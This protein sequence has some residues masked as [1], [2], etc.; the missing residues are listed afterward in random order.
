MPHQM[1]FCAD[2]T[3]DAVAMIGGFGS[4]K[5]K[6]FCYKTV[7]LAGLNAGYEGAIM[8]PTNYLTKHHLVPNLKAVLEELKIPYEYESSQIFHLHFREGTT[9]IYC[10]SGE[11]YERLVGYNLA[12]VGSDETDTSDHLIA[13]AMWEKAIARIRVG[14]CRQIYSTSTPEGYRFLHEYF[15]EQPNKAGTLQTIIGEAPGIS[16]YVREYRGSVGGISRRSIHC[17]SYEN[18]IINDGKYLESMRANYTDQQWAVWALGQFGNLLSSK[19]YYAFDRKE[20]H[21]DLTLKDIPRTVSLAVGMD[22][23]IDHMAAVIHVLTKDGPRAIAELVNIK[24]TP[25]MIQ[26]LKTDPELRGRNLIIYPDSSGKNR[27]SVGVNTNISLLEQAGFKC[28]YN[29]TNPAVGDRVNSMNAMFKNADGTRRYLV[30][31]KTCPVYTSSLEKQARLPNGEP[32]KS[33][34]IDHPLDAAGYAIY[35]HY[36]L[37]GRPKVTQHE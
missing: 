25:T 19:V 4:G 27:T 12:F 30:N 16:N 29:P 14:K 22:F 34:N 9:K 1:E 8:A 6:G 36:P 2:V 31:T 18:P 37:T 35:W 5:T 11:N 23:N 32:D 26:I 28:E 17:T 13:K 21:T 7:I 3:T 15:V 20:N 10:L 24:D 33:N